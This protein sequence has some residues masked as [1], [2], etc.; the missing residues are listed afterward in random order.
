MSDIRSR[1]LR[2]PESVQVVLKVIATKI[3]IDKA[4]NSDSALERYLA[5]ALE[6]WDKDYR[7][8]FAMAG[9]TEDEAAKEIISKLR[10]EPEHGWDKILR[11]DSN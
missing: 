2:K 4:D 7:I 9:M 6:R 10:T 3:S 5:I 8:N 1:I 11:G